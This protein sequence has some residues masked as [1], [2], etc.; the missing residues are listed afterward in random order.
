[1]QIPDD[2]SPDLAYDVARAAEDI[3]RM[4]VATWVEQTLRRACDDLADSLPH[5][6]AMIDS[7]R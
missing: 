4:D 3:Y 7:K 2:L 1:V 5:Y 6:R